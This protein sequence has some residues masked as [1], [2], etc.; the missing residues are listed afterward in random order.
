MAALGAF[1]AVGQL[2]VDHS[3]RVF[4]LAEPGITTKGKLSTETGHGLGWDR[5]TDV[6]T[7]T[8][9]RPWWVWTRAERF[10]EII[11]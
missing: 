9:T 5:P 11:E 7:V 2:V 4:H 8:R 6:K 1:P 10:G 3:A